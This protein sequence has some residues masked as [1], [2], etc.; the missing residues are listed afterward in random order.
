MSVVGAASRAAAR[1]DELS[2]RRELSGMV[3]MTRGGAVEFERAYG[4]ANRAD[5]IPVRL[6]TR[7]GL[8]SL[9]KM[10]TAVTVVSLVR[11]GRLE[12]G[13]RVAGVLPPERRPS[14][15]HPDV[16]VH[17]LLCHT[18]GVADYA[19]E[20]PEDGPELD[21]AAIWQD[22]PC[23][24]MLRPADFLPLFGDLPP[25]RGP[26]ERH[27]YSNAG[28]VL[29][30]L[31][32][33][34]V[35]GRPYTEVVTER[36]FE[37]AGMVSSGFFRLD[38]ALPDIATGYRPPQRPG[39]PWRS[40]VYSVPVIG[41]AGRW[42]VLLRRGPRPVPARLR[43]RRAGRPRSARRDDDAALAGQ[44]RTHHGVRRVASRRR[45]RLLLRPRR[46]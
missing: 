4:F 1:V 22:R 33:E 29:L 11:D 16:T 34:E 28:Y 17:H 12:F 46:R 41:G 38:E 13:A 31:V 2:A 30:G 6:G 26:G 42:R 21:Y 44:R 10:F 27:Q 40:N 39:G 20:E 43:P 25:Y 3:R 24:R 7:F 23:Y 14:T 8:A 37:P 45:R 19:E 35:T 15:L 5:R 32:I 9:T 18:S 36:V